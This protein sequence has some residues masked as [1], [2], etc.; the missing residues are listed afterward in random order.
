MDNFIGF[1]SRRYFAGPAD[2]KGNAKGTLV[3]GKEAT[4]PG[5]VEPFSADAPIAPIVRGKNE[6]GVVL[7]PQLPDCIQ[8]FTDVGIGLC[9]DVG[10]ITVF[11]PCSL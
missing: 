7:D 4:S 6:N 10:E 5:A 3:T 8:E 1:L 11:R 9:E 2:Q